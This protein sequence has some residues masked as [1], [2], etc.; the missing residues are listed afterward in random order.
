MD[1]NYRELLFVSNDK[2]L[3]DGEVNDIFKRYMR[4]SYHLQL[5]ISD[6]R[7]ICSVIASRHLKTKIKMDENKVFDLQGVHTV[8]CQ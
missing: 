4:E 8:V 7:Q 5:S 6:Y 1:Y 3:A 2:Q